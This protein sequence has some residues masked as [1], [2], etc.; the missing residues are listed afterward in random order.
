MGYIWASQMYTRPLPYDLANDLLAPRIKRPTNAVLRNLT[1]K[2]YY[3]GTSKAS[4]NS[5]VDDAN[6]VEFELGQAVLIMTCWFDDPSTSFNADWI[7]EY[8]R[9]EW[10]GHRL[11]IV[12]A[13]TVNP[14]WEDVTVAVNERL[15]R[16]RDREI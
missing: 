4:N 9:G 2:Q 16:I 10:A 3:R 14:D 13:E 15:I 1:L 7:R 11:D 5:N 6:D 8:V 12:A